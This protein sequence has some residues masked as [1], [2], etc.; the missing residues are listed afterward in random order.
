MT[1]RIRASALDLAASCPGSAEHNRRHPTER[2]DLDEGTLVHEWV[3]RVYDIPPRGSAPTVEHPDIPEGI[4]WD[5][6]AELEEQH[7]FQLAEGCFENPVGVYPSNDIG[8]QPPAWEVT[9]H[10]DWWWPDEAGDLEGEPDHSR[11][12]VLDWKWGAGAKFQGLSPT[13]AD[14]LQGL[15][16]VCAL[17]QG[18]ERVTLL[19]VRLSDREVDE[20][21]LTPATVA[22]V[23]DRLEE[24]VEHIAANP[25]V[26]TPGLHCE[27]CLARAHCP[28]YGAQL[29]TVRALVAAPVGSLT[30]P[31]ALAWAIAA[32]AVKE[33]VA[34][35]DGA[36]LAMVRA[37][38]EI[39]TED[40]ELRLVATSKERVVD[41][42]VVAEVVGPE[43]V[44]TVTRT[45]SS[46]GAI[47]EVLKFRG[48]TGRKGKPKREAVLQDLRDR[49][50]IRSE[51]APG[52]LRWGK[53]RKR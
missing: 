7:G 22:L 31:Q 6:I 43:A 36:L 44:K 38:A 40:R 42:S 26:R 15:A 21:E 47:E 19:R 5:W 32:P 18:E 30:P 2:P 28:E 8:G 27:H 13:M 37:G 16:Y 29:E 20:L 53:R 34:Q 10:P 17:Y 48:M 25:D 51:D 12:F 46:K 33:A 11:L 23:R 52:Y 3:R 41:P 49:G 24:L 4:P 1:F 9:G 35:L 14:W 45:T 39:R 50:A